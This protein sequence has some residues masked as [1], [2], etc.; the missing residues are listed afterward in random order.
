MI[1]P[2]IQTPQGTK[3]VAGWMGVPLIFHDQ[4]IGV[5]TLDSRTPG[6]YDENDAR[7]ATVSAN[8][9]AVAIENARLHHQTQVRANELHRLLE[10]GQQITRI[11]DRPK[12]VLETI[13]RMASLVAGADCA[14]VY[15]Y[16]A[17]KKTYD[18]DNVSSFGLRHELTP[19]DKPRDYGKSVA[20]RII[21]QP[22]GMCIVP[23]VTQ[24]TDRVAK[25]KSLQDSK[26]IVREEIKGFAGIRLDFGPEP[27]GVL[28]VNF[29]KPHNFSQDEL[30]IIRPSP[31]R[32]P[33]PS[34]MP[35]ATTRCRRAMSTPSRPSCRPSRKTTG[36]PAVMPKE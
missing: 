20:A 7:V 31:T 18:K 25:G 1:E 27:V 28:F 26:F 2:E 30:E 24:D 6:L 35:I 13:V 36:T 21:K 34:R 23:D 5:I 12:G 16:I 33:S 15:P 10:I 14:V 3:Q 11:T 17:D 22:T 29:R 19:S 4:V 9:A 32:P 8:Q